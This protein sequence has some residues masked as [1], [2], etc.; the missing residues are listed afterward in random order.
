MSNHIENVIK[1]EIKRLMKEFKVKSEG[2]LPGADAFNAKYGGE[3]L[4]SQGNPVM[5][6]DDFD[7]H[8]ADMAAAGGEPVS[9]DANNPAHQGIDLT[10][11]N[12]NLEP[13]PYGYENPTRDAPVDYDPTGPENLAGFE[14][15]IANNNLSPYHT[16]NREMGYDDTYSNHPGDKSPLQNAGELAGQYG[17]GLG[18]EEDTFKPFVDA[19]LD[20][21]GMHRQGGGDGDENMYGDWDPSQY[22]PQP[23]KAGKPSMRDRLKN[24]FGRKKKIEPG[25]YNPQLEQ[26]T[27]GL[28]SIKEGVKQKP[29][30]NAMS[31]TKERFKEI[32]K[33]E[34]MRKK[35]LLESA[36]V[37]EETFV[38]EDDLLLA[39]IPVG[40]ELGEDMTA[41]DIAQGVCL[42]GMMFVA[43]NLGIQAA[44]M[45]VY[46]YVKELNR[47]K[48]AQRSS[49]RRQ[50][51]I[52]MEQQ[53]Y[54]DIL[55][56]EE[57]KQLVR[58]WFPE[59]EWLRTDP[60]K[61]GYKSRDPEASKRRAA[62]KQRT[63][64]IR[65]RVKVVLASTDNAWRKNS[66]LPNPAMIGKAHEKRFGDELG[67]I[68]KKLTYRRGG[69]KYS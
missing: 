14:D 35:K 24:A 7:G 58:E 40:G 53:M 51:E 12:Y 38:G 37:E 18:L 23:A 60:P 55:D 47:K 28:R 43:I 32:V 67:S 54:A 68:P 62:Q 42:G 17:S 20:E 13:D 27:R 2:E 48:E 56:D 50:R 36:G 8:D 64:A 49:E 30:E 33:E 46:R 59:E 15:P 52:S 11:K 29:K 69:K 26:Y 41:M 3:E 25:T 16:A 10:A 63:L 5:G 19:S 45:T 34:I 21:S 44:G 65:E 57:V 66:H 1:E 22:N 31:L 9:Y 39:D 6:A 61:G 4:S